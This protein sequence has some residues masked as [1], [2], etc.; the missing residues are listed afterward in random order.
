MFPDVRT[1]AAA[2]PSHFA[3][4]AISVSTNVRDRGAAKS[5]NALSR[6]CAPVPYPKSGIPSDHDVMTPWLSAGGVKTA[7]LQFLMVSDTLD[8]VTSPGAPS[9]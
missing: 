5:A 4:Q 7:K 2:E 9:E 1:I 3:A 6:V 8:P